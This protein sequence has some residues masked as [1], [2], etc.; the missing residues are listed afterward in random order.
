M[1]VD[2][3]FR[4][5]TRLLL[6]D[7]IREGL[8]KKCNFQPREIMLFGFGQGAMV[9]LNAVAE[10]DE[11]ELGGVVSIGGWLPATVSVPDATKKYKTP[12]LLCKSNSGSAVSESAVGKLKD[13]FESVQ[14]IEWRKRGDGMPSNRDEMMPIMQFFARRLRSTRGV[15][16]GAVEIT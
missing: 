13:C 9:A 8:I 16:K 5:S 3:G 6:N 2:T 14:V 15:P 11:Q 1:D 7:V 10:M 4:R 12:V